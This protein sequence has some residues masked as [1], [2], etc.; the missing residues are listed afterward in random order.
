MPVT[1]VDNCPIASG[2]VTHD[3]IVSLCVKS[4]AKVLTLGIVSVSY[5]I[6]LS[7]DWLECHNPSIDWARHE[8][9]LSCC[10]INPTNP[11]SIFGLGLNRLKPPTFVS[12]LQA[13]SLTSVSLGLSLGSWM[14]TTSHPD[15]ITCSDQVTCWP[16]ARGI[17][18][19][20]STTIPWHASQL[21]TP[22]LSTMTSHSPMLPGSGI[23]FGQTGS[24][25]LCSSTGCSHT[26]LASPSPS[27]SSDAP[28]SDP[29]HLDILFINL[30][31]FHKYMHNNPST[32]LWYHPFSSPSYTI[33]SA[34]LD[35]ATTPSKPV[36][37]E[38]LSMTPPL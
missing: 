23:S 10:G 16:H 15:G 27:Q 32:V 35:D 36:I 11:I 19:L 30:A 12:S 22:V 33:A 9:A 6:I 20:S 3:V 17:P 25:P 13:L 37:P 24:F 38:P 31:C 2:F 21:R 28:L 8:L 5:L 34:S 7:L 18:F 14:L 4:H 26:S 1:A 29:P